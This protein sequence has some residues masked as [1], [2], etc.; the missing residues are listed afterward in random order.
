MEATFP[1]ANSS[2]LTLD[3]I[4]FLS[5]TVAVQL[6][7]NAKLKPKVAEVLEDRRKSLANAALQVSDTFLQPLPFL[8]SI[9][10]IRW[11]MIKT[12]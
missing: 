1:N 7:T 3:Q 8:I 10:P 9:D 2:F 11:Q 12:S 4:Q 5:S 6:I